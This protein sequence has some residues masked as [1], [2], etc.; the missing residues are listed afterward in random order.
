M[1]KQT[2]SFRLDPKKVSALDTLAEALDRD[3]SYL[4]NEA[5]TAYLDVQQW[6]IEQIKEGLRQADSRRL[7]NHSKVK[8]LA[9]RWRSG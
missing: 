1:D 9:A 6:Q 8:K 4:L 3:R 2:I 5:V 7:V